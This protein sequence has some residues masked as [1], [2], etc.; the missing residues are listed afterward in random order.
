MRDEGLFTEHDRRLLI[1][2]AREAY[3]HRHFVEIAEALEVLTNAAARKRGTKTTASIPYRKPL[4][5]DELDEEV[6][7]LRRSVGEATME[8]VR[9]KEELARVTGA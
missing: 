2:I 3:Q 7:T 1:A 9:L 8:I 4:T 6:T 5:Y